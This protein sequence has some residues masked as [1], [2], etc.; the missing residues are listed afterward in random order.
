MYYPEAH[1]GFFFTP[2]FELKVVVKRR[3]LEYPT[4]EGVFRGDLDDHRQ[5][6][7]I[8]HKSEKEEGGY[9]TYRHS[10]DGEQRSKTQRSD[11]A[12]HKS[13]WLYIEI[14]ICGDSSDGGG[15]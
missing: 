4:T 2:T 6:F 1:N 3:H 8:E 15:V 11:V 7:Y 9:L 14:R 12:H 10:I 13:S 5:G